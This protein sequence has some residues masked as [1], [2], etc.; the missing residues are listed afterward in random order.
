MEE[1]DIY[2][3]YDVT[4][5]SGQVQPGVRGMGESLEFYNKLMLKGT[6]F[7]ALG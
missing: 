4:P 2:Y 1:G 6:L 7:S 3:H 5:W